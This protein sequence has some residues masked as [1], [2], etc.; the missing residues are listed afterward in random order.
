MKAKLKEALK[1]YAFLHRLATN[2]RAKLAKGI[3]RFGGLFIRT[4]KKTAVFCSFGGKSYSC[5]PRAVSEELHKMAPEFRIVWLFHDAKR[6]KAVVPEYVQ[7]VEIGSLRASWEQA[8]A[9]FWIDNFDKSLSTYKKP[10]QVYI[11]LYHGDRGFKKILYD[12]DKAS[13][14]DRYI[15][16]D[17]C[18]L[19]LSG[20]DYYDRV[21]RSAF[22]YNGR[23]MKVG[24]P[25]N[26]LLLNH[27]KEDTAEIKDALGLSTDIK[28]LMY[29]PTLRRAAEGKEQELA[30][31][32][33]E[34]T[35]D[36]LENKTRQKWICLIRAHS[37]VNGFVHSRKKSHRI[38][39]LTEY[40]D[41]RDLLLITDMLITDYSSAAGDFALLKRPIILYQSDREKYLREDRAFYFDMET[42]P[43]SVVFDQ[44]QLNVAIQDL[45][46]KAAEKQCEQILEFYGTVETGHAAKSVSE[47]IL[48]N[49]AS[50]G[51]IR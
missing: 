10:D 13:P 41:M 3:N 51:K 18:D 39:D 6:K 11:Q 8:R 32:D 35:L 46:E 26:D 28:V 40:E 15:E 20:S 44:G 5:N 2:S 17:I 36:A 22:K 45:D 12:S 24:S 48:Q 16:Q 4:D 14:Y 27:T 7:C 21:I 25:R 31:I 1:H 38:V 30:D 9:G 50:K 42:S 43:F 37:A 33:L 23:I 19:M 49:Q 34:A 47:Y 29:A